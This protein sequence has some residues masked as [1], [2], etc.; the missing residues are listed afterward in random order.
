[1]YTRAKLGNKYLVGLQL[2]AFICALHNKD[3]ALETAAE[4]CFIDPY[5]IVRNTWTRPADH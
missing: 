4:T 3:K 1:M 5:F 2:V